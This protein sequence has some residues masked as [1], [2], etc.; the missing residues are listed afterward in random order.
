VPLSPGQT[1]GPYRV[2]D[3]IG[4]GGMGE[5]FR[6]HDSRLKRDAALKVL[7]ASSVGDSERRRRFEREAQVLAALNHPAIAQVYGVEL[8]GS[9]PIIVMEFVEGATLADRIGKGPLPIDDVVA[10]ALQLCDGLEAAH[11]RNVIHRDLK[12]ANIKVRPDG[13]IKILD[14]G[15]ARVLSTD[16]VSDTANS[17]TMLGGSTDAGIIL[18][19]AADMSPEQARGRAVDKRA[20]IW[21]FGCIV[22]EMLTGKP[23]FAGEST[24]DI[25]ADVVK[26]D[27]EWDLL[28]P[29]TPDRLIDTLKRCLQKNVKD[30]ARDIADVRFEIE[31]ALRAP[32]AR[33][34]SGTAGPGRSPLQS[35]AWFGGGALITAIAVVAIM[36][37]RGAEVTPPTPVRS[38]IVLP[39]STTLALGRGSSV[40]V[41]PDGRTIAYTARADGKTLL[42][43][44]PLDR[45]ES[46]PLAG[47]ED[48]SNPFFSPDGRWIG[49]FADEKLKKV[50]LDGGAPVLVADAI[51]PRGHAWSLDDTVFVTTSNNAGISRVPARGGK[52]EPYSTLQKGQLSH[53]WP[54]VLPDG[55][56]LLFS[57]WNDA[58]WE[59]SRIAALRSGADT[60]TM[61]LDIGGGYP[62]YV[63][64]ASGQG[65]LIYARS[66]GLMSA[67]FDERT[68]AL[69]TQAIPVVDG[70]LTNLSGGAH[71]DVSPSG[72]LAYVPGSFEENA[73]DL[74]WVSRE[75]KEVSASRLI[76]GLT[77][78]FDLSPDG[79]KV[80]RNSSGDIWIEELE[81]GRTT[82][83]TS[84]PEAGNFTGIWSKD[85]SVV[86]FARGLASN[87]DI[88]MRRSDGSGEQRLT[89]T[90][91][92]K[93][94][95]S[96]SADGR[97]LAYNEFDPVTL[98]DI[99]I[100][101]VATGQTRPFVKTDATESYG[102]FSP[103]GKWML[104]Q[105][106]DTGR[107]EIYVKSLVGDGAPLRISANGGI[108]GAWSPRTNEMVY[109]GLDGGVYA[110]AVRM[111][112]TFEAD[113]PRLLFQA[114]N[115]ESGYELAPDGQRF[116]M[117]PMISSETTSTQINIV[118]NFLTELRQRVR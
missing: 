48:A 35:L 73:R 118:Q 107:F 117:M 87:V 115:Y 82:R 86:A 28:P 60:P 71:F 78:T 32:A 75:G 27:P 3:K 8:D 34:A 113:K 64:D 15:I 67:G 104:Y 36:G 83:V 47:T 88:F 91:R 109:R 43:L 20:D 44:R 29:A 21:A 18:G 39:P 33:T 69:T 96:F 95:V 12:P 41:S 90:P 66:E 93:V 112:D 19:T 99:G 13:S 79:T 62:R 17:P 106:N 5:V 54:S 105:S 7:P 92:P 61:V 101:E 50:S 53:R 63:G 16:T 77:R 42:Y 68:S 24:T 58:G 31:Q 81:N 49:F 26:K 40:T 55:K 114:R 57:V 11:E 108:V 6:A 76:R 116:L 38:A 110:V 111:G 51:N 72:T 22:F 9:E 65:Y 70:V 85:G 14:F 80:L 97:W 74:V 46:T 98:G 30:R 4:E 59:V 89:S 52:L 102:Q 10:I 94:P 25:L 56:T 100:V 37:G 1:V 103:D 2:T 84:S 45:F 23:V